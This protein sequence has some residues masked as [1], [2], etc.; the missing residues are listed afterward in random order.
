MNQ[1]GRNNA[2]RIIL[3]T[4][5]QYEQ[6]EE[7]GKWENLT[8]YGTRERWLGETENAIQCVTKKEKETKN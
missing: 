7:V 3:L 8:T 2:V 1:K 5:R 6:R 4:C